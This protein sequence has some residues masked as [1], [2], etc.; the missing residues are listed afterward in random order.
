MVIATIRVTIVIIKNIIASGMKT[1]IISAMMLKGV[2][3]ATAMNN[4]HLMYFMTLETSP[5]FL[6]NR[7]RSNQE[8]NI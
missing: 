6:A 8:T 5:T 2:T 4:V 1:L 7:T 3:I